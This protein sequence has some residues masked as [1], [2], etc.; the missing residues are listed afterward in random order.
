M[1]AYKVEQF[2]KMTPELEEFMKITKDRGLVNNSSLDML[3]SYRN[4]K[5]HALFT[6]W[7]NDIIVGTFG[8]HSMD[9]LPNSYRICARMCILTDLTDYPSVRTL[10]QIKTNKHLTALYAIPKCIEWVRSVNESGDMFI[11]SHPSDVGTQRLVHNIYCPAMEKLSVLKNEG[12]YFYRGAVQT[13][14]KLNPEKFYE[15]IQ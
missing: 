9:F 13:F 3:Y 5:D 2:T 4:E 6:L 1:K 12:E 14:W 7:Y 8:A 11:T 15:T 10:N